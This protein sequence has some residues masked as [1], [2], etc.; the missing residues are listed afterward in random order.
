MT[1]IF[2]G[3]FGGIGAFTLRKALRLSRTRKRLLASGMPV[4]GKVV[5][6]REDTSIIVNDEHPW[7]VE[8]QWTHPSTGKQM[9]EASDFFWFDPSGSFPVGAAITVVVDP[10]DDTVF[11]VDAGG[12]SGARRAA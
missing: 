4:S 3:A 1:L 9:Q 11:L 6:V 5:K 12:D 7:V 2:G 8:A 10:E